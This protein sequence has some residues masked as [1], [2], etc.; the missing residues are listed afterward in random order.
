MVL[1]APTL[2]VKELPWPIIRGNFPAVAADDS[3][4][5]DTVS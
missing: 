2:A 3:N 5:A 4:A 1:P